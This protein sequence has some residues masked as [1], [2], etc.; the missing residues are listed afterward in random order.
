M[1]SEIQ[2]PAGLAIEADVPLGPLT[3]L[4][5]G[6]QADFL[7]RPTTRE[8]L[9]ACVAWASSFG[10][11]ICWLGGGSN[12]VIA[13]A[14]LRGLV[15]QPRMREIRILSEQE[16]VTHVWAEA[17]C[18]WDDLVR[19]SVEEDLAGIECLSGIPGHVGA[20]PIQNIGA[21]GQE[22]SEVFVASELWDTHLRQVVRWTREDWRFAYRQSRLKEEG[23]GRYAVLSVTLALQRGGA[24]SLRYRD[25][26]SHF[27]ETAVPS[28][29]A[30]REAVLT[31]RRQKS[32]VWD[33]EDPNARSAG[34][35][36]TNPIVEEHEAKKA[37]ARL[38]KILQEGDKMPMFPT[39]D[40]KVKLSAAWLIER[41]GMPRGYGEGRV[42][43]STRHTLALVNRGDALASEVVAFARH[44]Q[45]RVLEKCGI[46]LHPEPVW[47]GFEES[48]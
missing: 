8:E 31:I 22:L 44:I 3:T 6:G 19:W 14:G 24:P 25:L 41:C 45:S 29:V 15:I 21:Y 2:I 34:S 10:L 38:E 26:Q 32:M 37:Y 33:A 42:G 30:V 39:A 36:F 5:V 12:V 20:A 27:A 18:L 35:F 46:H 13:D 43:L 48:C 23:V 1:R 28:L 4:G 17:G 16:G 11:P 47:L 9:D 7:A 40:G